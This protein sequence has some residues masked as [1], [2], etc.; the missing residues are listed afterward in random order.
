MEG[1][2]GMRWQKLFKV[3][4][5]AGSESTLRDALFDAVQSRDEPKF[6]ALCRANYHRVVDEF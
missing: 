3:R 4:Q 5:T 1:I 6:A 2:T